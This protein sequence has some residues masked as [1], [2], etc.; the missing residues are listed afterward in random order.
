MQ[1]YRTYITSSLPQWCKGQTLFQRSNSQNEVVLK[2][3][4]AEQL[5][6][7]LQMAVWRFNGP[8]A[9]ETFLDILSMCSDQ[10][11]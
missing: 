1:T 6:C 3:N 5:F 2:R 9:E 7:A 10:E 4:I 8:I 11:W